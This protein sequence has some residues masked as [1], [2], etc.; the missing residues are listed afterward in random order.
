MMGETIM[1]GQNEENEQPKKIAV[2]ISEDNMSAYL[3][4]AVP[5]HGDKDYTYEDI[6]AAIEESGVK[7]GIDEGQIQTMLQK[8]LYNS[9]ELIATGKKAEDGVDGEYE[10][11]FNLDDI[12]KPVIRADGSVDYR[13]M[14]M[15]ELVSAGDKLAEYKPPTKGTFGYDVRGKL[16]IPKQGRPKTPLRGKGFTVSEDGNT[17][18]ASVDGKVEYRNNDLNVKSVLTITGNVDISVGNID[19]NGDVDIRGNVISGLTVSA[20][21]NI[22]I[23]G[24][25]EAAIIRAG[26]NVTFKDGVNGK[27]LA[28]VESGG[29]ISARF[30]EN[31]TVNCMGDVYANYMLNCNVVAGGKVIIKGKQSS[32]QGGDVMGMIGVEVG[33]AGVET[34]VTTV[35]RVGATKAIRQEYADIVNKIRDIDSEIEMLDTLIEKYGSLKETQPEKFQQDMYN[36]VFQSKIIKNSE[37][38]KLNEDAMRLCD[39]IYAA[40]NANIKVMKNLYPGVKIIANGATYTPNTQLVSMVIRNLGGRINIRGI[41]DLE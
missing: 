6:K 28:K 31:V 12:G 16:L 19:F 10:L 41:M 18:Y 24:H 40:E 7:M 23:G 13:N 1:M 9:N 8:K 22:S 3:R 30:L 27:G 5:T 34:G 32:I 25:V 38:A 36:K 39:L 15:F 29:N 17:Y 14:K 35:I 4:L 2:T 26:G 20:K 33:N 21:G 11:F 37:K